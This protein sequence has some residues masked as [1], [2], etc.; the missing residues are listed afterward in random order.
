MLW[1][2]ALTPCHHCW[3]L[4]LWVSQV[5]QHAI[6]C[7]PPEELLERCHGLQCT[8][9]PSLTRVK[10]GGAGCKGLLASTACFAVASP[11]P[12]F[13]PLWSCLESPAS[14]VSC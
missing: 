2:G 7:S 14:E 13:T 5:L 6:R 4:S 10:V 1:H 12:G 9:G 11:S 8:S 3:R